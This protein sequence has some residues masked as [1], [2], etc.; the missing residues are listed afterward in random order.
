MAR[1]IHGL[2]IRNVGN[3]LSKILEKH[4]NYNFDSSM[5]NWYIYE[6]FIKYID[7]NRVGSIKKKINSID[8][9]RRWAKEL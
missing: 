1:F 8:N 7:K 2:G 4:Y 3:H 9:F 5:T 6:N